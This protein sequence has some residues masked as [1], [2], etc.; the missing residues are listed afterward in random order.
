VKDALDGIAIILATAGELSGVTT[1]L[2]ECGGFHR[3]E[4]LQHHSHE[5]VCSKAG[6]ILDFLS[7]DD[8]QSKQN[9]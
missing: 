8:V 7:P 5:V 1:A 6:Q 9:V 3:I 2:E 4:L